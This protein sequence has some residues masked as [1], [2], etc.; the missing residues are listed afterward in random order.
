MLKSRDS[1]ETVTAHAGW[2]PN[3]AAG[4][5]VAA[6]LC[7][8]WTGETIASLSQAFGLA[9]PD[10]ASNLVRRAKLRIDKSREYRQAIDDI[11]FNPG[12]NTE[13]DPR[14]VFLMR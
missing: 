9:H 2:I 7:R 11:E 1:R 14:D 4:R 6:L 5:E 12:L 10:S 8:R 13:T 3:L